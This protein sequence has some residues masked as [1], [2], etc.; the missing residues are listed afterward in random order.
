MN[1]LKTLRTEN[2]YL[3]K[4]IKKLIS[5]LESWIETASREQAMVPGPAT[6]ELLEQAKRI[7]TPDA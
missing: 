4:L 5:F 3:K 2:R 1:E 6:V 7:G